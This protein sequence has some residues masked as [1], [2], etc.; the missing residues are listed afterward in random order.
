[1]SAKIRIMVALL[2][3]LCLWGGTSRAD[4]TALFTTSTAPD[5]LIVLD[6]SGS[7]AWNPAGDDLRYG[8]TDSCYADATNCSGTGCSGGFCAS[9][10][11]AVVY[12]AA[13]ACATP[14]TTN[15]VGSNCSNG[16]CS[17]SKGATTVYAASSC[18]TPDTANCR[19]A[20]CGRTDGFCNSS[21]SSATYYAHSSCSTPDT[22]NCR[23]SETWSDCKDGFC[24]SPHSSYSRSC[25]KACTTTGCTTSC[26]TAACST[27]CTSGGC[28]KNCSRLAIAKRSVF[29]ILDDNNDNTINTSDETSLGVR[30]GYMRFYN[31]GDDDTG[32]SYTD[33]CNKLIKTIGSSFS[34]I[35]T[36]VS[37][38]SASGGTPLISA[39]KEAKLYLDAHKAADSAKDCRQKFVILISDGSDTYGCGADGSECD[40]DRYKN[41]REAVA[42]AKALGDAGYK[43]F[44]IGFGTA[45]PPYLRN[46]LNW[47]AYYGGTDNPNTA[48]SG[49]TTA[50]S[51][52]TGCN[53]AGASAA[54]AAAGASAAAAAAAGAAAY[55]TISGGGTVSAAS[56]AAAAAAAAAGAAAGVAAAAGAAASAA[57]A[58][59]CCN[60]TAAA[61]Y[62]TGVTSC[63]TASSTSTEACY[64]A[65]KPYPTTAPTGIQ[66]TAFKASSNDP[67]YL[68]LSGYAFLAADADQLVAA[69]KAAITIIREATYSFSQSSIQSSRTVDENF[70]YEGSFQPISGDP[71]WLGHLKKYSVNVDGT[72]GDELWDA[73]TVLK[74]TLAADRNMKTYKAGAL[75]DFTTA[76]LTNADLAVATDADRNA[77]VGYFRGESAYNPENWKL[78]DVFRATPITVG[79]PSAY[80]DDVRDTSATPNAFAQH[81][82]NHVRASDPYSGRVILAGANDGQLHAFRTG[83]GSE[84]WSFIPP[85]VLSRLK[86]TAHATEPSSLTHQ[87]YV[88]GPVTVADAWVPSTA[89]TGTSKNASDWKTLLLFGEGRGAGTNLWSSSSSCDSGFNPSYTSTYQYYCGYYCLDVNI[90]PPIPSPPTPF[91]P[92]TFKWRLGLS[93]TQAPYMGAPWSKPMI[94]RILDG[95][96]EKWVAFIGGGASAPGAANSGKGFF[97]IDLVDGNVLWSYTK[98]DNANLDYPM[99]APPAIVDTDNDGFIDTVY[100]GDLGGH[101][102]RFT[103]CL[104]SDGASC[105]NT[106][107]LWTGARLFQASS[108]PIYTAAAVAK[109]TDNKIWVYWGTGDK[110]DPTNA[111][112]SNQIF[113]LKDEDRTATTPRTT[114]NMQDISSLAGFTDTSKFGWYI[115][116]A[117]GEKVLADPT[118]FGGVFYA[119]T[120]TPSSSTNPCYQGGTAKLYGL[121]YTTGAGA[122]VI[123]ESTAPPP[124]SI[125]VGTGIPSAPIVSLKPGGGTTPDL[126]VTTSGSGLIGAQTQRVNINPPGLANRTNMLFWKDK[127]V[128]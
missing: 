43:V 47:M 51:I 9:S 34:S 37:A 30:L 52:V 127:R 64:D 40:N 112:A 38:E 65:T 16:F 101:M 50:Y 95:G 48:N 108:S 41:R 17:T 23:Y 106:S 107:A 59:A 90:N 118:V 28:T 97:V 68:D 15:C 81:R 100:L 44:V 8:S 73:G 39:L 85:N 4:E 128:E 62:P 105:S 3:G 61:C 14:D 58:S 109:D 54:A 29:N 76:N 19:G 18:S 67:G 89:G 124:R 110:M 80:F 103:F 22:Y 6:L 117:A 63:G 12:Y 72:V 45:M 113:A 13:A 5:A 119:T 31:C 26:P 116:L 92:P 82:T 49:I 21:V 84:A 25:T 77:V 114:A 55:A 120:F 71:V 36:S 33:G 1:M 99:P 98:A 111:T 94:S 75:I 88:D 86:L 69:V 32:N 91:P 7:M 78:G 27:P 74:N 87:Y 79:T 104:N 53:A 24:A 93:S 96:N 123:P 57:M 66:T 126:Y 115:S 83:D 11:S 35:N 20:G 102:W 60:L 70:I 10:K 122:L 46:T 125:D 56:A 121:N 2:A 42:K